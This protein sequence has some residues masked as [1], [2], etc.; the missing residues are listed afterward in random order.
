MLLCLSMLIFMANN[1]WNKPLDYISTEN[2]LLWAK[3]GV[4]SC[5]INYCSISVSNFSIG[6]THTLSAIQNKVCGLGQWL[7]PS[8][9]SPWWRVTSPESS[10]LNQLLWQ[11]SGPGRRWLIRNRRASAQ[12]L[13]KG[14]RPGSQGRDCQKR[15]VSPRHRLRDGCV[16]KNRPLPWF[17]VINDHCVCHLR[18]ASIETF[19][20]SARW[21]WSVKILHYTQRMASATSESGWKTDERG[22]DGAVAATQRKSTAWACGR[23]DGIVAAVCSNAAGCGRFNAQQLYQRSAGSGSQRQCKAVQ[24]QFASG[25]TS[26]DNLR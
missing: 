1:I 25:K 22:C 3:K 8:H 4:D 18:C 19:R 24:R 20:A 9:L 17:C 15:V 6:V 12:R 13:L 10:P 7:P 21:D 14:K 2:P 11:W 26:P 16:P 23:R 5:W